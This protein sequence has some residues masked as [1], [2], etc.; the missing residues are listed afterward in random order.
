MISSEWHLALL[1]FLTGPDM[2]P[3][4][5]HHYEPSP[6][7]AGFLT[8]GAGK[9]LGTGPAYFDPLGVPEETVEPVETRHNDADI[10]HCEC[11]SQSCDPLAPALRVF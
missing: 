9:V 5:A 1:T 10:L 6:V 11:R 7:L 3:L 4:T 2:C 8:D